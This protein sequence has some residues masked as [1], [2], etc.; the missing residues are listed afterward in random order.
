MVEKFKPAE[1]AL[2]EIA[3]HLALNPEWDSDTINGIIEP[4]DQAGLPSVG[5]MSEVNYW[6]A[7]A[8]R[9]E[10]WHMYE[11]TV[12]GWAEA[13]GIDLPVFTGED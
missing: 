9:L 6:I 1:V 2:R 13:V 3:V 11:D 7:E 8:Q 5:D 12:H 4:L 10:I